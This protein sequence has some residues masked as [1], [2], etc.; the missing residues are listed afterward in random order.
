M[1]KWSQVIVDV[2]TGATSRRA[3]S[4]RAGMRNADWW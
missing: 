2:E 4:R 3:C 1:D